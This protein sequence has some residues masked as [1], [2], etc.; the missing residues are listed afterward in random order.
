MHIKQCKAGVS[1]ML[2]AMKMVFKNEAEPIYHYEAEKKQ[3]QD[4]SQ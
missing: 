1:C 3:S 2:L 4:P